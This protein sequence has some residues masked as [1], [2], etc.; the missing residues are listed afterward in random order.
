MGIG[1]DERL[2]G[3]YNPLG[4]LPSASGIRARGCRLPNARAVAV[5]PDL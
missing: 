2:V 1:W 3:V 4:V 5:N